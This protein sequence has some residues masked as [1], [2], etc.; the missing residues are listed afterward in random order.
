MTTLSCANSNQ[1]LRSF[2]MKFCVRLQPV[3]NNN[4]RGEEDT[5]A[6]S[7]VR[8]QRYEG[9]FDPYTNDL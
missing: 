1:F 9:Q 7:C 3:E 4:S 8:L 6:Q 2:T 5:F